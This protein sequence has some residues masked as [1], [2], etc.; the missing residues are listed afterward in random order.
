MI[1]PV[2]KIF[3]IALLVTTILHD[4]YLIHP[5]IKYVYVFLYMLSYYNNL[6]IPT[7]N[8][9]T[10]KCVLFSNEPRYHS[11]KQFYFSLGNRV[12]GNRADKHG[13]FYVIFLIRTSSTIHH[14]LLGS[15][16]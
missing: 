5:L 10:W 4:L 12:D 11:Y 2:T 6:Q 15:V 16:L 14:T 3:S 7:H 8:A 1:N 9:V 13:F